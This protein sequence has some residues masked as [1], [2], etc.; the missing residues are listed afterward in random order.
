MCAFEFV[1]IDAFTGSRFKGNPCAV[2]FDADLLDQE[3]KLAIAREMNLVETS[4]VLSPRS[5][6]VRAQYYTLEEEI[7]LAGHPTIATFQ[8][9]IETGRLELPRSRSIYTLEIGAGIVD[10]SLEPTSGGE[11]PDIIMNQMRPIFGRQVEHTVVCPT[12]ALEL[13]DILLDCPI[14]VVSTG[15][16]QLMV[17]VSNLDALAKARADVQMLKKI[18]REYDISSVHLFCL[19]GTSSGALTI[20]RNFDAPPEILE[21]PFT[22]SATGGMAAYLWHH[23]VISQTSF[24]AEQGH[25]VGRP[26][27]ATVEIVTSPDGI[28]TV[29]VGGKGVL[30]S[31]GTIYV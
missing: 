18:K 14:Q 20:A 21:D 4:F 27:R 16:P 23:G 22:G 17:P 10:V 13:S 2:V 31:H 7:L 6:D 15:T 28:D 11:P 19:P 8:A 25:F 1:V 3:T 24:I 5:S 30:V 26:G 9:L 29:K 12:L